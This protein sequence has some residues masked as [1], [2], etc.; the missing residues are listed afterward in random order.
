MSRRRSR[1]TRD[2]WQCSGCDILPRTPGSGLCSVSRYRRCISLCDHWSWSDLHPTSRFYYEQEQ[3]GEH[4]PV[5]SVGI[6]SVCFYVVDIL[7]I[8]IEHHIYII[9]IAA[10]GNSLL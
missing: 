8:S 9:Y 6:S 4:C 7:Y 1:T 10:T 5:S 2:K 3:G